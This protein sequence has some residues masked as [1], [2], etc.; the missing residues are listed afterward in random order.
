MGLRIATNI[1]SL[2]AQNTLARSTRNIEKSM[3]NKTQEHIN[4]KLLDYEKSFIVNFD[5]NKN[6]FLNKTDFPFTR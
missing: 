3:S 1:T 6:V 2:N 5:I 4:T